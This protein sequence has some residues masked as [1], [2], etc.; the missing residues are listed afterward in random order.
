[1]A[2]WGT[3][4]WFEDQ[5]TT[6]DLDGLGDRWGH[7]WRGS[8]KFRHRL[9]LGLINKVL[10]RN[11]LAILDVGCALGDFTTIVHHLNLTNKIYGIDISQRAIDYVSG[12]YPWL[13]AKVGLLPTIPFPDES[14]DL[15]VALEV[16]YYL[17]AEDRK[18]SLRAIKRVLKDG[19]Y[20]F[21]SVVLDGGKRYFSEEDILSLISKYFSLETV[22]FNYAKPYTWIEKRLLSFYSSLVAVQ[23][24]SCMSDKEFQCFL[25]EKSAT[26]ADLLL[27][28]RSILVLPLLGWALRMFL[29][30][31]RC[32]LKGILSLE[33]IPAAFY[34]LAK[35]FVSNTSKSHIMILAKNRV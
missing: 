28:V 31:G 29:Q 32:G 14:F 22:Q 19:D 7:R 35:I 17:N 4:E 8:Q 25:H 24:L 13:Q 20:L 18:R 23:K 30:Y 12:K 33:C 9:S 34:T 1:M 11:N 16:L 6:Q 26:K 15:V 21:I 3:A 10:R 27:K 2:N 5:F